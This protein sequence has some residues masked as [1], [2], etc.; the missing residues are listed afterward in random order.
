M[1][2]TVK[3]ILNNLLENKY[4]NVF[5]LYQFLKE[6]TSDIDNLLDIIDSLLKENKI[7]IQEAFVLIEY[8]S[9]WKTE[10]NIVEPYNPG[11]WWRP[12]VTEP[13]Y[14]DTSLV[15]DGDYNVSSHLNNNTRR[16]NR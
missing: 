10:Q 6:E 3:N 11:W 12:F 9:T 14:Q 7:K 16:K 15:W 5:V 4:I 13:I 2:D 1:N 8:I